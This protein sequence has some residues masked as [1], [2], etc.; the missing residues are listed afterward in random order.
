MTS[1]VKGEAFQGGSRVNVTCD[2]DN[3]YCINNFQKALGILVR[4][5]SVEFGRYN[6]NVSEKTLRDEKTD[7]L[8]VDYAS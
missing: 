2:R 8:S 7:M 5:V 4:A 6:A 3:S 1:K